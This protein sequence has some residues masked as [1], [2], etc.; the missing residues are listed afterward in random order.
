[1]R[2]GGSLLDVGDDILD[3]DKLT[4]R[5]ISKILKKGVFMN[6]W[7]YFEHCRVSLTGNR[8]SITRDLGKTSIREDRIEVKHKRERRHMSHPLNS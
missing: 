6:L 2:K 4:G 8:F 3:I 1:M 5:Q 7:K